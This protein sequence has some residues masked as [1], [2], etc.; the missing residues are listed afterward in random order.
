MT[1][2]LR[3]ALM[4]TF[5]ILA[6]GTLAGPVLLAPSNALAQSPSGSV[7]V[8]VDQP[9]ADGRTFQGV[10]EITQF[11]V[12]KGQLVAIG[13]LSGTLTD[14]LGAAIGTVT[15][16]VVTI[17]VSSISGTCQ[18]LDLE[19]GP[20]DLD[21]LGLQV[22]LDKIELHID[23]QSGS[24]NLL[25]NLLCSVAHLLDSQGSLSSLRELLNQILDVL[26]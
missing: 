16:L 23:A 10:L 15:D 19:L 20:L 7:T 1:R 11:A 4:M 24:G 13:T 6:S 22:H 17:P 26:G 2:R 5:A 14:A 9:L 18:V 25:G 8:P 21:I 12:K 3:V